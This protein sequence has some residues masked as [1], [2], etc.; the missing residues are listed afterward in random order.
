M[1][2]CQPRADDAAH[3][4]DTLGIGADAP[5]LYR[6]WCPNTAVIRSDA[7]L[8]TDGA[9]YAARQRGTS[10]RFAIASLSVV[11]RHRH[12]PTSSRTNIP[13]MKYMPYYVFCITLRS[14]RPEIEALTNTLL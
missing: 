5:V 6:A 10:T 1:A 8:A 7:R 11:T 13:E 14:G 3:T 12:R 4:A 2:Q 9:A